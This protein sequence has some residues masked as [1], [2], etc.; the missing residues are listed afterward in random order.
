MDGREIPRS[1]GQ[2]YARASNPS[3]GC[4][5]GVAATRRHNGLR[6]DLRES[7]PTQPAPPPQSVPLV[8]PGLP[9][10]KDYPRR[11]TLPCQVLQR[12]GFTVMDI[13]AQT[14]VAADAVAQS[15]RTES[16]QGPRFRGLLGAGCAGCLAAGVEGCLSACLGA[17]AEGSLGGCLGAVVE[18]CLGAC[19]AGFLSVGA[20]GCLGG[21]LGA[22]AEGCLGGCLGGLL[23]SFLGG[24]LGAGAEGPTAGPWCRE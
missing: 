9:D 10:P 6:Q 8:V 21:C 4:S 13:N 11:H 7:F 1:T 12:I 22:G 15:S 3:H 2:R 19:L 18:E 16:E 14:G 17:R 20:E 24:C 23:S 5:G